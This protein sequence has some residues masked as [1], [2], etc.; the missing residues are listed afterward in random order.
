[1][2]SF[3]DIA[4]ILLGPL[5]QVRRDDLAFGVVA[6]D[7]SPDLIDGGVT[8]AETQYRVVGLGLAVSEYGFL[9]SRN[10]EPGSAD[11]LGT[12]NQHGLILRVGD[13]FQECLDIFGCRPAAQL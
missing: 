8:V 7:E 5:P 4:N 1:M 10:E 2:V 12:V 11:A 6:V 13:D 9:I 3:S